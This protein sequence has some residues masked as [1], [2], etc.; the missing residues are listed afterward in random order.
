MS[1]VAA[2]LFAALA[3]LCA[4]GA[5]LVLRRGEQRKGQVTTERFIDSRMA[6][7]QQG[8]GVAR[9][10]AAAPGVAR[11]AGAG[12]ATLVSPQALSA[13]SPWQAKWRHFA[14]RAMF[15]FDT[16]MSREIGRAH[17]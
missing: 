9:A 13:D 1:S 15:A 8:G 7:G 16:A 4:A 14:A 12:T 17:V 6:T 11:V 2:L 3:L 5:L 10:A